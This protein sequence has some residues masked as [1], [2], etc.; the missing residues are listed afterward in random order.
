MTKTTTV[1]LRL[2]PDE[3]DLAQQQ[4]ID[5]YESMSEYIRRLVLEDAARAARKAAA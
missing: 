4:A 1:T 3:R 2:T 5:H